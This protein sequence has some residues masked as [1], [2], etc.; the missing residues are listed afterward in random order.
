MK[1]KKNIPLLII[2]LL[3]THFLVTAQDKS[4]VK[5]G[6][7]IPA[8]F[9]LS[10][11][12]F[13]SSAPAVVI[14]DIGSSEIEQN[15]RTFALVYSRFKRLKIIN[16]SGFAAA[17]VEIPLFISG[18]STERIENLKAITYN[19]ENGK[20]SEQKLDDKSVFTDKLNKNFVLE[21]F[22]FP[23]VKEG[24]VIEYSYTVR[25]DFFLSLRPWAF[26]GNYPCLWSEYKATI[27]S[28]LFYVIMAQGYQPFF[29]KSKDEINSRTLA[30]EYRWVMKDV[31][32]LKEESFTTTL[33][34][35]YAKLE[36]QLSQ[37]RL[38]NGYSQDYMQNWNKLS[39]ELM[40]DEYFGADL[41]SG[42]GWLDDDMKSIVKDANGNLEKARRIYQFI[43]SG[44]TCT[45]YSSVQSGEMLKTVFKNKTGNEAAINL[46]L[47]AMRG[48]I[49]IAAEPVIL[50]TREHGYPHE[51][52]PLL[53]RFNYV[54]CEATID[55]QAYYLD[56]S[57]PLLG[58]GKL[59]SDCYNGCARVIDKENSRAVY[60]EPDSL[61]EKKQ[62][63][64][65]ISNDEKN[66][67]DISG[68]IQSQYGYSDSYKLRETLAKTN[69][70]DYFKDLKTKFTD[71]VDLE[72]GGI[73]S[74]KQ[75]DQP[76]TVHYD[77]SYKNATNADVIY[78]SPI[79][80]PLFKENPLKATDRTY[81]VEMPGITDDVYVLNM[82][83]PVGYTVDELPKSERIVLN[84][85]DGFFEYMIDKD[86]NSIQLRS[87]VKLNKTTF[88]PEDYASLRNFF[89]YVVKK[90][91][92]QIVFKKK[93]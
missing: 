62:V 30:N 79:M 39:D 41:N 85:N 76:V 28:I 12:T 15:M 2:L 52:Y 66:P 81:P 18:N 60:F 74:L 7:I 51:I 5:F 17:T 25:S 1:P 92:D 84:E 48:H 38:Q 14:A 50:S 58:F 59:T 22:T 34:N 23:G 82:D 42:N 40:K 56:A 75:L 69:Q 8:D 90:Q 9:D 27:P 63:S 36:F 21:K 32:P 35:H 29:I 19:L 49:G 67:K 80:T 89:A 46:I 83:I 86:E 72:N 31:P 13:D 53:S 45:N 55:G 24:S 3:F 78:F 11:Y 65:F 87:R 20:I 61:V 54:I 70:K 44:F 93:K 10:K 57:Q 88:N 43:Q 47:T 16:K 73:D 91:G 64:V 26:Q 33:E 6:K 77:F 37:I 4:A 68:N 71:D